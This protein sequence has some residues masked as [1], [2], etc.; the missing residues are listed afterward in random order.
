M[1]HSAIANGNLA[2]S[3][4]FL[5]VAPGKVW[6]AVKT[7][8]NF[9]VVKKA[10]PVLGRFD[11]GILADFPSADE[12]RAFQADIQALE[13]VKGY[14]TYPGFESWSNGRGADG[15]SVNGIVLIK[16][17]D[18][19]KDVLALQNIPEIEEILGTSGDADLLVWLGA[20]DAPTLATTILQRIQGLPGIR[21]TETLCALPKF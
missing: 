19:G 21:A 17:S 5:N 2:K 20:K 18:P 16:T 15:H 14:K 10:Y 1:E 12:L 13:W 4:I 11:L 9:P 8:R 3:A 6:E 7:L